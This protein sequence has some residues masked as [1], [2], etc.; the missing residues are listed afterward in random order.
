[1]KCVCVCWQ[2]RLCVDSNTGICEALG[3][4]AEVAWP[5]D[6]SPPLSAGRRAI[7]SS[8]SPIW[9]GV[10]E[11]QCWSFEFIE[12]SYFFL[13]AFGFRPGASWSPVTIGRLSKRRGRSKRVRARGVG[14]VDWWYWVW[15][16]SNN[17][18][19]CTNGLWICFPWG[20]WKYISTRWCDYNYVASPGQAGGAQLVFIPVLFNCE[21][22]AVSGYTQIYSCICSFLW[23]QINCERRIQ[24][25]WQVWPA[26]VDPVS[27]VQASNYGEQNFSSY[28]AWLSLFF[29][30]FN[31]NMC[32]VE[33][34]VCNINLTLIRTEVHCDH[35]GVTVFS[36]CVGCLTTKC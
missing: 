7:T 6:L 15:Q 25:G 27:I 31:G 21:L 28:P 12:L 5:A 26:P 33:F 20:R 34:S 9:R 4:I 14:G 3:Q 11:M 32:S 23:D 10:M 22:L 8:L 35:C 36:L 13:F 24:T 1:M 29:L 30:F 19:F 17:G 16:N 18:F 2:R